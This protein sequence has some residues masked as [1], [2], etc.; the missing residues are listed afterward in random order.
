MGVDDAPTAHETFL[1][2][3]SA[4]LYVREIGH[5]YPVIVVHGG[6][7]FDHEYLLP[8]LDRLAGTA[9]RIVYYDQRGRGRSF[10]IEDRDDVTIESDVADLDAVRA[11]AGV[12]QVAILGHS[13]GVV[14]ALEY[15]LRHPHRV[16]HLILLNS[17]PVSSGDARRLR[18]SLRRSKTP[19]QRRRFEEIAAGEDFRGGALA[20]DAAYYRIHFAPALRRSDMLENVVARLRRSFTP[21]GIVRARE[22]EQGL[23]DQTWR[24]PSYDLLPQ[25]TRLRI[26]ALIVHGDHDFV[27]IETA[28]HI[29]DALPL[30]RLVVLEE[31]GHFAYIEQADRVMDLV[32]RFVTSS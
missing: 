12:E 19:E 7:D 20:A 17:A 22:I 4:P 26:P 23:Y 10:A 32:T 13:F 3:G 29:A 30:S 27:P 2:T 8:E 25:L 5:G 11:W 6:P 16:G 9:S 31:C 1:A 15:A 21:A 28:E 14:L 24:D 18:E